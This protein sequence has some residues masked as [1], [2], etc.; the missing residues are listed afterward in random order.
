MKSRR[1]LNRVTLNFC[2]FAFAASCLLGLGQQTLRP[3]FLI[4]I[5]VTASYFLTDRLQIFVLPRLGSYLLMLAGAVLAIGQMLTAE[6]FNHLAAVGNLLV[7]VQLGLMFQEKDRRVFEQWGI[8]LLLEMIVAALVNDNLLY[9]ML[10]V[11]VLLIGCSALL[12]YASYVSE[13]KSGQ[14]GTES[15]S[16]IARFLKWLGRD[17]ELVHQPDESIVMELADSSNSA[18]VISGSQFGIRRAFGFVMNIVIFAMAFFYIMPRLQSDAYEGSGWSRPIV[19]FSGEV[20]LDDVG[21]LLETN[22]TALKIKFLD[23]S[24]GKEMK[25]LEPPYIRGAICH[26]YMGEGR[27]ENIDK[28]GVQADLLVDT[29]S[30]RDIAPKLNEIADGIEVIVEE[31]TFFEDA[32]FSI[33]PFARSHPRESPNSIL[34]PDWTIFDDRR[35]GSSKSKRPRYRFRSFGFE[36]GVQSRLL[37]VYADCL[38]PE[39][40]NPQ[41]RFASLGRYQLFLSF[42]PTKFPGIIKLRESI[43]AKE[44]SKELVTQ[45][46]ALEDYLVTSPDFT[47]SLDLNPNKRSPNLDPIEDFASNHRTGHCQYFASTMAMMLRSM[48]VPSRIVLGFRPNDFNTTSNFFVVRQKHAHSWVEAF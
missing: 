7:Y 10:L 20:S 39:Q 44:E 4:G 37:P 40:A 26:L 1:R 23:L 43:L 21:Q 42:D 13:M 35:S 8:F 6:Q 15:H 41:E 28:G 29:P 33:P 3:P 2:L 46:L 32:T 16:W 17:K 36:S 9:G 38:S 47:Y 27:W 24:N 25:P 19:G 34:A 12:N 11:P 31:Q 18:D 5:G 22:A 45:I 30:N 14:G 48:G